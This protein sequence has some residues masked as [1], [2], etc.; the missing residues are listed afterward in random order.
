MRQ[1]VEFC[2]AFCAGELPVAILELGEFP[3]LNKIN[4]TEPMPLNITV[5]GQCGLT[6]LNSSFS[7]YENFPDEYPF[8][9]SGTKMLMQNLEE[10]KNEIID[11]AGIPESVLDIGCND[12]TF[13]SMFIEYDIKLFGIDPADINVIDKRLNIIKGFFTEDYDLTQKFGVVVLTNTFAHLENPK[14]SLHK[15]WDILGPNGVLVIEIVDL[16]T[17]SELREFDKFTHEHRMYLNVETATNFLI[18]TG[19]QPFLTKKIPTHGGSIRIYSRKMDSPRKGH[20][21][22]PKIAS[23][24]LLQFSVQINEMREETQRIILENQIVLKDCVG[25]GATN[26]GAIMLSNLG[27]MLNTIVDRDES[28]RIGR[29][30]NKADVISDSQ[31]LVEHQNNTTCVILAWHVAEEIMANLKSRGYSG[32]FLI[33]LPTPRF[34]KS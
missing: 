6:Q 20:L 19:F 32:N 3:A 28:V 14:E 9:T 4:A 10:L 5:C 12:G 26:R 11:L 17:M 13:L 16:D 23:D 27:I 1:I 29:K 34:Y 31:F 33:L 22:N 24:R 21:E 25:L 30:F 18:G 7:Q 15:I 8:R 2:C